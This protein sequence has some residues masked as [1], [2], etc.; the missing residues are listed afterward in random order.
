M[1]RRDLQAA[2]MGKESQP[3]PGVAQEHEI[4]QQAAPGFGVLTPP[5]LPLGS[6]TGTSRVAHG[7]QLLRGRE[8]WGEVSRGN[9]GSSVQL[10]ALGAF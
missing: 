5:W 8:T 10:S 1:Q 7:N 3:V 6:Q 9:W 4:Q 2:K